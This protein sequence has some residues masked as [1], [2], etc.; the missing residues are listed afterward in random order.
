MTDQSNVTG[1]AVP[2]AGRTIEKV[3][4]EYPCGHPQNGANLR[5]IQ[6]FGV[7]VQWLLRARQTISFLTPVHILAFLIAARNLDTTRSF[8]ILSKFLL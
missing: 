2:L 3:L 6:K 5:V 8:A 4:S 7:D 1:A